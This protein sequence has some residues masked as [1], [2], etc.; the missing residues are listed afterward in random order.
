MTHNTTVIAQSG[1]QPYLSQELRDRF[2]H[3]PQPVQNLPAVNLSVTTDELLEL[4]YLSQMPQRITL[5]LEHGSLND[6]DDITLNDRD[7][8]GHLSD[9]SYRVSCDRHGDHEFT[10]VDVEKH[11]GGQLTSHDYTS[12][13][14]TTPDNTVYVYVKD[15]AY[16]IGLDVAG[17]DLSKRQ[18]KVF[19]SNKGINATLGYAFVQHCNISSESR[20]VNPFSRDGVIPIETA[21]RYKGVSVNHYDREFKFDSLNL[22]D[23][24]DMDDKLDDI[25]SD[26]TENNV[27]IHC[28]DRDFRNL[29]AQKKNAKIAG[30]E[31]HI[32]FSRFEP[33]YIDLKFDD[34]Q[35]DL[36]YGRPKTPSRQF[37]K[38]KLRNV[39]HDL[40][41]YGKYVLKQSGKMIFLV[42]DDELLL[43]MA[44]QFT[45]KETNR[46]TIRYRHM[47][48]ETITLE[49]EH[50]NAHE[51]THL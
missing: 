20:I 31:D 7:T 36:I 21:L 46:T 28:Y 37:P 48:Y 27:D 3:D 29:K 11:V 35:V 14:L 10:S 33:E 45:L 50:P 39:Y 19:S 5:T 32:T 44:N 30:V 25:D 18:Y 42:Q 8:L 1:L 22:L 4:T 15:N 34:F 26:L 40:F 12:I 13:D 43:D 2:N 51:A 41:R 17:R 24:F 9:S 23:F 49:R 6:L 38:E 16:H 47:E